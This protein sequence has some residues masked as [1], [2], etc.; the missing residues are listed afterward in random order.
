MAT[1]SEVES[2]YK[3]STVVDAGGI[4]GNIKVES[5]YKISTVV[6]PALSAAS[7]KSNPSIRFL[8]L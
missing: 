1:R 4:I 3:I 7:S 6:D 5:F 2:F 8:L